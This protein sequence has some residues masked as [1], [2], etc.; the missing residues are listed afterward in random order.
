ME[1]FYRKFRKKLTIMEILGTF[2]SWNCSSAPPLDLPISLF[3][4]RIHLGNFPGI[5]EIYSKATEQFFQS[6]LVNIS[7][8]KIKKTPFALLHKNKFVKSYIYNK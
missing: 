2:Y 6:S 7:I 8:Y 3:V 1:Y 5:T 4:K